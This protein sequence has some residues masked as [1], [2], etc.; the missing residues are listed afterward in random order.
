MTFIINNHFLRMILFNNKQY[1]TEVVKFPFY[2]VTLLLTH[3]LTHLNKCLGT[4]RYRSHI[5]LCTQ[6][7]FLN[8]NHSGKV[9]IILNGFQDGGN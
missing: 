6:M 3:S 1:C 5:T 2:E 4:S 9:N 7:K 8:L